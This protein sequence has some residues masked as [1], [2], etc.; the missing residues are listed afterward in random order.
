MLSKITI[1]VYEADETISVGKGILH[2]SFKFR[3]I[4]FGYNLSE[5][6]LLKKKNKKLRLSLHPYIFS[7]YC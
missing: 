5:A 6:H 4:V 3:I 1:S 2:S 7:Q